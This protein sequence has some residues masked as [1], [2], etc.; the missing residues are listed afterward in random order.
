MGKELYTTKQFV[1]AIPGTGGVIAI[2]AERTE[3]NRA[4][5]KQAVQG[6]IWGVFKP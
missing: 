2:V 3:L 1:S 6:G 5:I 4:N